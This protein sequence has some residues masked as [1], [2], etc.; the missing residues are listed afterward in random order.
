MSSK[1]NI[2]GLLADLINGSTE[3]SPASTSVRNLKK[4]SLTT[5]M[6]KSTNGEGS[7]RT[8]PPIN[9]TKRAI[10][11]KHIDESP[12]STGDKNTPAGTSWYETA[13]GFLSNFGVS[14]SVKDAISVT[15]ITNYPRY[16]IWILPDNIG[17]DNVLPV[18]RDGNAVNLERFPIC[19]VKDVAMSEQLVDGALLRIDFENRLISSDAYVV[20]VMNNDERFGRAIFAELEGLTV[21]SQGFHSCGADG[22]PNVSHPSGDA[23]AT[24]DKKKRLH[25]AY[26]AIYNAIVPVPTAMTS[27]SIYEKLTTG[28][29]DEKIAI[30][31][32]ANAYEESTY[33]A[34]IV[35]GKNIESSLGLWQMNVGSNGRTG[36]PNPKVSGRAQ[37]LT[38]SIQIPLTSEV[39]VYFGGGVLAK[40]LDKTIVT[41]IEYTNQDLQP[42]YDAVANADNQIKFVIATANNML[43]E[44]KY[45]AA[46]ITAGQWAQ[47]WQIYFEQPAEIED[48]TAIA[49][50]IQTALAPESV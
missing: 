32:L 9:A 49:N 23:V 22:L 47:W 39:V 11:L 27:T 31:I 2:T 18:M 28:G 33:K 44:L 19:S 12:Q 36:V 14:E 37:A 8:T 15:G 29:L 1:A 26:M 3:S 24:E 7:S 42:I 46:D 35:S 41:A 43:K 6:Q 5:A 48:R 25:D 38:G 10:V 50:E 30:G 20:S 16:Y 45:E 21:A 40:S 13:K 34:K 17:S 4:V